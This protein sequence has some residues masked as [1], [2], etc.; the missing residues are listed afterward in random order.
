MV[1]VLIELSDQKLFGLDFDKGS[2]A[3]IKK[4]EME[5]MLETLSDCEQKMVSGGAVA[6]SVIAFSQLGGTASFITSINN[7]KFGRHYAREF[8]DLGINVTKPRGAASSTGV[9]IAMITP[10]AQRTMRTYI[11][12]AA[13][14]DR[15]QIPEKIIKNAQWVLL[16]GY[17]L[18]NSREGNAA[19]KQV[20]EFARKWDTKIAVVCSAPTVARQAKKELE[21]LVSHSDIF[22]INEREAFAYTDSSEIEQAIEF[23]A[24]NK[25]RHI[26]VTASEKGVF[27]RV[28]GQD[29]H[30]PAVACEPVDLTGAGDMFAGAYLYGICQKLTPEE[31]ARKA[32][33]IS[34]K[35]ICQKGARFEGNAKQVWNAG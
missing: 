5:S 29:I 28:D 1:D 19:L 32:C 31:S 17:V 4:D 26:V 21:Y 3:L 2:V 9:C 33:A 35:L 15:K 27:L 10:D 25:V 34:A 14:L 24:A 11:G 23:I 12:A 8:R 6:N 22:F 13:E 7:D 20:V 16:E 18:L 30:V